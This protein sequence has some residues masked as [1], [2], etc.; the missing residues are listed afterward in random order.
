MA[1]ELSTNYCFRSVVPTDT[2]GGKRSPVTLLGKG[3]CMWLETLLHQLECL[4]LELNRPAESP[5]CCVSCDPGIECISIQ[6]TH[7]E[8]PRVAQESCIVCLWLLG[9]YLFV[10]H[11][12]GHR[13]LHTLPHLILLT[14]LKGKIILISFYRWTNC[15]R[16]LPP[17]K[18]WKWWRKNA[19]VGWAL[20]PWDFDVC[21]LSSLAPAF[22]IMGQSSR[23]EVQ[24]LELLEQGPAPELLSCVIQGNC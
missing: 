8:E 23:L 5:D 9:I 4:I 2:N 14:S 19:N 3:V 21:S 17:E 11:L 15:V 24:R 6:S 16:T 13:F 20:D 12:Y 7:P 10:E 22:I 18:H 1:K